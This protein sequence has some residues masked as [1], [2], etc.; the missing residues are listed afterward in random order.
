MLVSVTVYFGVQVM[1][2]PLPME[3]P[4]PL[5]QPFLQ[6]P[7]PGKQDKPKPAQKP[8]ELPTDAIVSYLI[9]H[10]IHVVVVVDDR[11]VIQCELDSCKTEVCL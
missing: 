7:A 10:R 3:E 9:S 6:K 8:N 4:L 1:G 5:P 2:G 11:S